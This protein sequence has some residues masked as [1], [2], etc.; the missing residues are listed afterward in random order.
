MIKISV[1]GI[2]KTISTL[3]KYSID[4][5]RN[6]LVDVT[7]DIYK[8]AKHNIAKHSK[9]GRMENSLSMR[10]Q[11]SKGT[12]QVY[13]AD[14]GMMVK[15]RGKP[16]NYALFVHFGSKRHTVEPKVKSALRWSSVGEF[17]YSKRVEHPGYRGDPFM[18]NAAKKTM[19]NID[20][21]F[22]KAKNGI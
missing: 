14:S 8:N 15:W 6:M 17:V 11:K 18:T 12:A 1:S 9:E 19:N 22:E 21:I 13:V 3:E 7:E 10:V 20:K 5:S 16:I 4:I 2:E